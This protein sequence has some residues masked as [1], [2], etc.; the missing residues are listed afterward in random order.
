MTQLFSNIPNFSNYF[1]PFPLPLEKTYVHFPRIAE[2]GKKFHEK[3]KDKFRWVKLYPKQKNDE[4]NIA[5]I[6]KGDSYFEII[7]SDDFYFFTEWPNILWG[8]W[9]KEPK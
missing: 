4:W 9:I 1:E 8:E 6:G 7:G 3:S 5:R 2:V